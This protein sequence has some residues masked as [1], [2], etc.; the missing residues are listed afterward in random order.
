MGHQHLGTLPKTRKWQQVVQLIAAGADVR[1]VAA[2]TSS[3]AEQQMIKA[4]DDPGVKNSFWFL[5][6]IPLAARQSDFG[7]LLRDL[8]LL[9][10]DRPTLLEIATEM[11]SAID[12][13]VATSGGRTDLGEMAQL[14]AVES[15]NAVAGRQLRDLFE[16]PTNRTKTVLAGLGTDK[17]FAVLARDFFSRLAQRQLNYFLSRELSRHVG[18]NSRFRTIQQH[19]E[20]EVALDLHCREASRILKQFSGE[21][22]SKRMFE[23]GISPEQ[24]GNFAHVAFEKLRAEL[25]ERR[26]DY[27]VAA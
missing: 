21:W 18:A 26:T 5:T 24:A 19:R 9:V 27:H 25:I 2:G 15:L 14:S 6:Q 12:R 1:D 17:Q 4:S 23:G 8:G 7:R 20:F 3:A 16:A 10:G 11:T 22:F 13:C